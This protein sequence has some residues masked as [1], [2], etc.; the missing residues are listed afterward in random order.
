MYVY[1]YISD[2]H[3]LHLIVSRLLR[4]LTNNLNSQLA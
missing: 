3:S 1:I 2:F 4:S